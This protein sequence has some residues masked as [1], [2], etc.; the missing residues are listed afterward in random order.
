MRKRL[1]YFSHMSKEEIETFIKQKIHERVGEDTPILICRWVYKTKTEINFFVDVKVRGKSAKQP[2][3][4]V[5]IIEDFN[6]NIS[7]K[8]SRRTYTEE[9]AQYLCDTLNA[10]AQDGRIEFDEKEYKAGYNEYWNRSKSN[11]T[12]KTTRECDKVLS[13]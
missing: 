10:K 13:K 2:A 12:T 11:K 9:W 1:P 3:L 7:I 6:C 8:N 5:A 4:G